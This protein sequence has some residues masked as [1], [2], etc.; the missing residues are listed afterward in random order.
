M[1]LE[2][3]ENLNSVARRQEVLE[4][5]VNQFKNLI[6]KNFSGAD[7]NKVSEA[8]NFM[9][10]IHLPQSDRVDGRPFAS[11][12]L[13]VAEKVLKLDPDTD[14]VS[15]AL[16]HDGVEDQGDYIF[17]ARVN[18]RF[19]DKKFIDLKLNP[20]LKNK[21]NDLFKSWSFKEISDRFGE[22]VKYYVENMTNHDYYSL[23]DNL[24]L[25][26]EERIDFI[27]RLYSEHVEAVID[28]EKLFTL[29]LADLSVNV[30]LHSLPIG[31]EKH[32]K[33]KRKY[34]LVIEAVIDKLKKLDDRHPLYKKRVSILLDL[35]KIYQEQYLK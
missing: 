19:P 10:Q 14:L 13:A 12:P 1:P 30:D 23:A 9:L 11:H 24:G 3:Y 27:N 18:R 34:K 2:T 17:A 31:S 7:L 33:L 8:L 15:A 28:D 4:K 21:Y 29:K 25:E 35:E 32:I 16:L 5:E 22:K 26:G 6:E 20:D